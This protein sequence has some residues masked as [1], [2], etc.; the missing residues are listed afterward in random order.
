[1]ARQLAARHLELWTDPELRRNEVEKMR[2]SNAEWDFMGRSF[3][4][5]ALAEMCLRNPASKD[6]YLEVIDSII[7]ETLRLESEKGF[8]HFL[9]PYA[10]HKTF[11]QKPEGSLFIDGEIALMLGVRRVVEEKSEYKPLLTERVNAMVKRMQKSPTMCSESYPDECWVF[12]NTVALAS[13]R[14]ADFLDGTDH[15]EFFRKWIATAKKRLI[16]PGT[17]MLF[18]AY[19]LDGDVSQGPEG[20]SIWLAAHCLRLIDEEFAAEQY[21]IAA[22]ELLR[23]VCGFGYAREWPDAW[24]REMDTGGLGLADVDSGPVVPV[25]NASASSSGLAFVAAASF[26]DADQIKKLATS[27]NFA[28]FPSRRNGGLKYCASN[29]V[30]DAVLLYAAVLGPIWDKVKLG[31]DR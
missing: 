18:S 29:Q 22:R 11:V 31:A 10:R 30:G 17:G 12:C 25:L 20:S 4:V 24:M 5:W 19:T 8:Y 2:K 26:E 1:M 14:V 23:Q 21:A 9:M 6:S 28:G 3:L 7:D 16:H 27:L 13:I 15:T